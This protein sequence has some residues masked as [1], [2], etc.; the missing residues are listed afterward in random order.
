MRNKKVILSSILSLIL[1]ASLIVGATF[2]LATSNSEVNIAIQSG[3]VS[4]TATI[5][6][7]KTYSAE[8]NAELTGYDEVEQ[9]NGTFV[10]G[11]TAKIE[12]GTLTLD[13]MIHGDKATFDIVLENNS[14]IDV[15][16]Q[17]IIQAVEDTGLFEGLKVTIN[18]ESYTGSVIQSDWA[19]LKAADTQD[20]AIATWSCSVELP[21]DADSSYQNKSTKIAIGVNAVQGNAIVTAASINGVNY[22]SFSD[23]IEAAESGDVIEVSDDTLAVT[24]PATVADGVTIKNAKFNTP[25]YVG[26]AAATAAEEGEPAE[27]A[28]D[29]VVFDSCTFSGNALLSVADRDV[30]LV[31]CTFVDTVAG[32]CADGDMPYVYQK[33]GEST[34][35]VENTTANVTVKSAA[36]WVE[37]ATALN[38]LTVSADVN[39]QAYLT[40]KL[41]ADLDFTGITD[42]TV[43]NLG[44]T[45]DGQGYTISNLKDAALFGTISGEVKNLNVE[46]VT[47]IDQSHFA[48]FAHTVSGKVTNCNVSD[49]DITVTFANHGGAVA[50]FVQT[51]AEGAVIDKCKVS[52][53][54]INLT[55]NTADCS[56]GEG[57]VIGGVAT[58]ATVQNCEFTNITLSAAGRI[59][60][61]GAIFGSVSGKVSGCTVNGASLVT[62][63]ETDQAGGFAGIV[64]GGAEITDCVLNNVIVDG[65]KR[66]SNVGGMFGKVG[67][68]GSTAITLKNITVNGLTLTLGNSK[69]NCSNVGGFIG[70]ADYRQSEH[71]LTVENCHIKDLDMTLKFKT[72]GESPSAGFISSLNANANITNCSV[73]GKI[74]GTGEPL[75]VGG[76][77][78]DIGGYGHNGSTYTVNIKDSEADVAITGAEGAMVGGFTA[79]AGSRAQNMNLALSFTNCEATGSFYGLKDTNETEVCTFTGCKV[80]GAAFNG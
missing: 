58:G 64:N 5:T 59:K 49:V 16:Y 60:R 52:N 76:F 80:D 12:N 42:Y 25:V 63:R 54:T 47:A 17:T 62:T 39:E 31:G 43:S 66:G 6:N 51:V 78:G 1:C 8:A 44:A 14:N 13:R 11:G 48:S 67:T 74:D 46:G 27:A 45:I 32:A 34:V 33:S 22:K 15:Q 38:N 29:P 77:L 24:M 7:L 4:V 69:N 41:G 9:S 2:S 18:S 23:A 68:S 71:T 37:M 50:G 73:S 56:D 79:Y 36:K 65:G 53:V 61:G 21:I 19:T 10:N 55:D 3:N 40:V 30:K 28:A 20:K 26:A 72:S 57:G 75:G 70:Q 35:T